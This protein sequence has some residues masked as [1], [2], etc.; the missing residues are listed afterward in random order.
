MYHFYHSPR[1]CSFA[2]HVALEE[3]GAPYVA[4]IRSA[5]EGETMA[6]TYLALN[7]K[8]R[9]PALSGVPGNAGGAPGLLTEVGAILVYLARS[10]PEARLLPSDPASEARC[11][12]WLSWLSID[13]HGI[14]FARIW[15]PQRFVAD[16]ALFPAV[17]AG[18]RAHV[19]TAFDHIEH[20][21]ADGRDWAVPGQY[22]VVDPYLAVFW[23]WGQ[24]IGLDDMEGR[25]PLFGSLV[26][27]VLAR[28]AVR[29]ALVQEASF[30]ERRKA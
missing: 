9:V 19:P 17:M 13:L 25:W 10:Y 1:A 26:D 2:V 28:P 3:T 6:E 15:R 27:K 30:L 29:R 16:A 23:R 8:G 7:P 14:A 24:R 12:E 20:I 11:L 22:T 21:L 5:E 4:E 18:G